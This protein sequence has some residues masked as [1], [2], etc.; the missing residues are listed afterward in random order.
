MDTALLQALIDLRNEG[1]YSTDQEK[2][3]SGEWRKITRAV[4]AKAPKPITWN[5]CCHRWQRL[6]SKWRLWR[7]HKKQVAD[8]WTWNDEQDTYVSDESVMD[9]Y[10]DVHSDLAQFRHRGLRFR[11]MFGELL[12]DEFTPGAYGMGIRDV[13]QSLTQSKMPAPSSELVPIEKRPAKSLSRQQRIRLREQRESGHQESGQQESRQQEGGQQE[14]GQQE[15]GHANNADD[16]GEESNESLLDTSARALSQ[17]TIDMTERETK[18]RAINSFLG[19]LNNILP[20]DAEVN[21]GE[22]TPATYFPMVSMFREDYQ[23]SLTYLR[24]RERS[25]EDTREWVASVLDN[26]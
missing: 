23:Q 18:K 25:L 14:D 20:E 26:I 19:E 5:A 3:K 4:N 17:A 9:A 15:S 6:R 1:K 11:D 7:W 24:L 21:G 10:F 2:V 13:L 12:D 16:N 22:I 8:S